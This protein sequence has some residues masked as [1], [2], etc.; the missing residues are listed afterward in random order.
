VINEN[1]QA[2]KIAT[3]VE[4][5]CNLVL[6]SNQNKAGLFPSDADKKGLNTANMFKPNDTFLKLG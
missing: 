1:I 4:N 5:T 3:F 2:N 6:S